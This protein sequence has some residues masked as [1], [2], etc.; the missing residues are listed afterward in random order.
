MEEY[1]HLNWIDHS[2]ILLS[3][4]H[5]MFETNAFVDLSLASDE[6]LSIQVHRV[7]LCAASQYF[8]VI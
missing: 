4:L 8:Q 7:V 3:K 2:A 1:T 6:G 5:N